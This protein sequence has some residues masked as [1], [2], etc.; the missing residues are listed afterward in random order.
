LTTA[1][2][3]ADPKKIPDPYFSFCLA[4][5]EGRFVGNGGGL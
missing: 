4:V 1:L 3:C 2:K 5:G